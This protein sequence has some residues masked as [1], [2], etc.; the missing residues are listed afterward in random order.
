MDRPS[1][2]SHGWIDLEG[3]KGAQRGLVSTTIDA[4]KPESRSVDGEFFYAPD[5]GHQLKTVRVQRAV[6]HV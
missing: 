6:E 3:A 4:S 2:G 5:F 1:D